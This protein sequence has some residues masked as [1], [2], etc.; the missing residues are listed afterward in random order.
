MR[1]EWIEAVKKIE[2]LTLH[3]LGGGFGNKAKRGGG[4]QSKIKA[5]IQAPFEEVLLLDADSF[6]LKDPEYLF[7][8]SFYKE[9]GVVLWNDSC[10]WTPERIKQLNE[11][12]NIEIP[13]LRQV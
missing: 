13:Y 11:M 1:P 7:D 9:H 12:Y 5:I 3:D 4:W 2:N 8:H 6:P 10:S